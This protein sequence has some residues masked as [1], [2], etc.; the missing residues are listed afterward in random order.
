MRYARKGNEM[1]PTHEP[2]SEF[3]ERLESQVVREVQRH[4]RAI[5]GRGRMQLFLAKPWLAAVSASLLLVLVVAAAILWRPA[6]TA[7]YRLVE[8]DVRQGDPPSLLR[9]F[10]GT[11][12]IRTDGG[13]G[14]VLEM[15]DTSRVEMRSHTELSLDRAD[16]GLR[17]RLNAGGII[18]SAAQQ[19]T[20]H[21]Y[22]QTNEMT[23]SVVGTV[24]A[25]NADEDGSRVAVIEGEVRVQQGATA[26][27][28]LSGEQVATDSLLKPSPVTE[29]IA[30]SRNAEA[31]FALLKQSAVAAPSVQARD[32]VQPRLMFEEASVRPSDSS[33]LSGRGGSGVGGGPCAGGYVE[34]DPRRFAVFNTTLYTLITTAYQIDACPN[35]AA[36]GRLAGGPSWV[37]SDKWDIQASIPAGTASYTRQQFNKGEAPAVQ[38]MVQHLLTDRFKLALRHEKKDMSVYVLTVGKEGLKL[39]AAKAGVETTAMGP[40]VRDR[41]ASVGLNSTRISLS[42]LSGL[43][44]AVTGGKLVLDRTNVTGDFSIDISFVPPDLSSPLL[45]KSLPAQGPSLFSA[46]ADVGLH[47]EATS[48]PMDVWVIERAEKPTEIANAT[49]SVDSG[50]SAS[51][52]PG[53][54]TPNPGSDRSGAANRT[55]SSQSGSLGTPDGK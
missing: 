20:G 55:R 4:N 16:D 43:L 10:G 6:D 45:V 33:P 49:R 39:Q 27:T 24:F 22:V 32:A 15:A 41:Q 26:K 25:V 42:K 1:Q 35:A 19:R 34:L 38:A 30:W 17:I 53:S 7:R 29:A 3:V 44:G 14:A 40:R 2:R 48:A 21:L 18:V 13:G 52:Q 54:S 28:L 12:T 37:G 9:S 8:G 5:V 47:L 31:L 50:V 23:V 46:L 11:G 36:A 51:I